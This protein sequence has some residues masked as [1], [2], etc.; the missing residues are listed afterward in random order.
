MGRTGFGP[1][2]WSFARLAR[3]WLPC[4]TN[5]LSSITLPFVEWFT[6]SV[7]KMFSMAHFI[8]G[9]SSSRTSLSVDAVCWIAKYLE[10]KGMRSQGSHIAEMLTWPFVLIKSIFLVGFL[11][12]EFKLPAQGFAGWFCTDP[13]ACA[14]RASC[15]VSSL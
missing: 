8:L 2:S 10:P 12:R 13:L 3:L 11:P 4:T 14:E 9:S 5:G 7:E 1:D 15:K 6:L